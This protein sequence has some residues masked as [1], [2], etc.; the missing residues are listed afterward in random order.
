M[1]AAMPRKWKIVLIVSL[2]LNLF[3]AAVIATA[4]IKGPPRHTRGLAM[5]PF[6]MPWA[7]RVLGSDTHRMARDIF[8]SHFQEYANLRE[9]LL[10]D[11][12]SLAQILSAAPFDRQK[13][14]AGLAKLW[15]DTG[16]AVN[17]NHAALAEF[18]EKISPQQ[19]AEL[20]K[21]I[22]RLVDRRE[23]RFK[24]WQERREDRH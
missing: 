10:A 19:R 17:A 23:R 12:R 3:L 15:Q 20:A 14:E 24:H 7:A 8:R 2:V 16:S 11:N 13:F 22:N 1:N 21:A 6:S 4:V 9:T 18:A 5:A